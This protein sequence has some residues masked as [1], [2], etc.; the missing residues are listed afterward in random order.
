M[1]RAKSSGRNTYE[2]YTSAMKSYALEMLEL[3]SDLRRALE[4]E[5]FLLYLQPKRS[6]E[7]EQVTGCEALLRWQRAGGK[8]VMPDD[9]VPLL[10]DSGLIKPVGEWVIRAACRQVS[11]WREAG[12]EPLPIA[13][14]LSAKQFQQRDL[15]ALIE[16]AL[17]DYGVEACYL[18]IEITESAAMQQAEDSIV[19]LGKL[20]ALGL[21]IYIDDFGKGHS[22]LNYL[23]RLPIDVLKIDRSFVSALPESEHDA[24]IAKAIITM[25]HSLGLK[26]LAEGVEREQ[27]LNFLL[28]HGCDEMQGYLLSQPILADAMLRWLKRCDPGSSDQT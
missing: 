19:T 1:L 24:S 2:F 13:I 18:E 3:E 4:R 9:F 11:A 15:H 25:A 26:V 8:I 22:S 20:K 27:Q 5:E 17:H 21:K 6:F 7:T 14:N 28:A 16:Q 12:F 23:K 10:E